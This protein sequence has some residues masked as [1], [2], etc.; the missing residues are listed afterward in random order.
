MNAIKNI[1]QNGWMYSIAILF[2]RLVPARLFRMRRFVVYRIAIEKASNAQSN[3][4]AAD[5]SITVHQCNTKADIEAVERMT[6]FQQNRAS[7]NALAYGVNLDDQIAAGMWAATERFDEN[8]LGVRICLNENQTWLFAALVPKQFRRRGLYSR[9]LNFTIIDMTER[10]YL[11]QL[12]AVNPDN[13]GSNRIHQAL[14]EETM[15]HVLVIRLW[16]TACCWTSGNISKDSTISWNAASRPI[17][18]RFDPSN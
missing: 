1:K 7:G 5:S 17:G 9:L 6:Y 11:D 15:G 16:K 12:V 14:S 3:G 2:N 10:G 4:S 8:E 18:I 13:I